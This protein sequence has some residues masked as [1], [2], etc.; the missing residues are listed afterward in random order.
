VR[1]GSWCPGRYF[2]FVDTRVYTSLLPQAANGSRVTE[3]AKDGMRVVFGVGVPGLLKTIRLVPE[4]V[5]LPSRMM[6]V[7]DELSLP[8]EPDEEGNLCYVV[9]PVELLSAEAIELTFLVMPDSL[10]YL[11]PHVIAAPAP[12]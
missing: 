4:I 10:D 6:G 2:L 9:R 12:S 1:K 7:H 11:R 5:E 3:L 8:E